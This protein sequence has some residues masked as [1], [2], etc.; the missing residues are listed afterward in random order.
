METSVHL[1]LVAIANDLL[2]SE[3]TYDGPESEAP[4]GLL[5]PERAAGNWAEKAASIINMVIEVTAMDQ[6]DVLLADRFL[7]QTEIIHESDEIG[8]R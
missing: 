1:D 6:A 2:A 3:T 4:A 5:H 8:F 7:K